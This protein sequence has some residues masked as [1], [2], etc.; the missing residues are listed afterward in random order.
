MKHL[1]GSAA[2]EKKNGDITAASAAVAFGQGTSVR[3]AWTEDETGDDESM[4]FAIDHSYGDGSIGVYTGSGEIGSTDGSMWGIGIGHSL[5]SG[6]TV[7]A[8]YRQLAE[9]NMN[10]TDIV[11][12]GMRV[13]FN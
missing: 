2:S 4:F 7:F 11:I 5:G 8:G 12:A 10:D 13:T 3:A 1:P 6:A 9:D